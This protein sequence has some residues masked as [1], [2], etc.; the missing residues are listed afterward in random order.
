MKL[1]QH[2]KQHFDSIRHA[3]HQFIGM[4]VQAMNTF[5]R[6]N[7]YYLFAIEFCII[8]YCDIHRLIS[9]ARKKIN[10]LHFLIFFRLKNQ[11]KLD[12]T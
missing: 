9:N 12:L 4:L 1:I 3:I 8:I 11:I 10:F 7:S 2:E 5:Y 6:R